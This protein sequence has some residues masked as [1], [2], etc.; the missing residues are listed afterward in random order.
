[1]SEKRDQFGT[2]WGFVATA[3][4][5]AIG[6]GNIWRFPREVA[7]NGGGPFL[8]A[9]T[10]AMLFWAVPVLAAE[11]VMGRKTRLGTIGAF[12]DFTG[13]KYTWM[14]TWIGLVCVLIMSYY[15]VITGWCIKYTMLAL[16]G[17][18]K[19][20]ITTEATQAI[21]DG[22]TSSPQ[23]ILFHAIAIG[24][25]GYVVMNGIKGGIE[26]ACKIMIPALF[27]LLIVAAIRA[28]TLPGAAAGLEYLFSPKWEMLKSSR[29]WVEAFTQASWS[30]GAGWGFMI[31]YAVYMKAKDD[32]AGNAMIIGVGDN[33]GALM[34]G[35]VVLPAVFALSPNMEVATQTALTGGSGLTF[36]YLAQLFGTMPGGNIIAVFF[37]AAMTLAALSSLFPMLEVGVLNLMD[38]GFTRKKATLATIAF[39]FIVGIPSAM[40]MTFFGNQDNVTAYGL[41]VSGLFIMFA[42]IKYGVE[43]VRLEEI[44]TPWTDFNMGKWYTYCTYIAPLVTI[45]L[46]ADTVKAM[47]GES[48]RWQIIGTD[49]SLGTVLAQFALYLL[50]G[51][52][53]MNYFNKKVGKGVLPDVEGGM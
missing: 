40:S 5:M 46:L 7:Q 12:R 32:V 24:L 19:P 51:F 10:V 33:I 23:T 49:W 47:L 15:S 39:G 53:T 36:V 34:A 28:I 30:T 8:I 1:M 48:N 21:W 6:T 20:G 41:W 2:R 22:F 50:I 45:W 9:W 4:G 43:K 26:K 14:G 11:L 17:A 35:L 3:L 42:I 13:K 29:V 52:L 18:F 31:T 25:A 38:M 44:N 27:A 16:T 37:F